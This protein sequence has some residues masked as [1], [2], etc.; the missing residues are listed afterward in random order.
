MN[1]RMN[2]D[3]PLLICKGIAKQ[4]K[5]PWRGRRSVLGSVLGR[6]NCP[7]LDGTAPGLCIALSGGNTDVKLN[8]LLPIT[9]LTHESEV[10]RRSCVP[11]DPC[12]KAAAVKRMVRRVARTQAQRNGYF[13]GYICKRQ[14][15]GKLEIRKCTE[16]CNNSENGMQ[17]VLQ[18]NS[19]A[20]CR[21]V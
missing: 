17:G 3:R 10:C 18:R 12:K 1:A 15:V 11:H 13:G 14:K 5:L 20:V 6:R 4:R 16:K 9:E 2:V 8:D 19:S 7:W 21:A